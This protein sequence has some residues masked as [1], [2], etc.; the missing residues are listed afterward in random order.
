MTLAQ[1]PPAG[2][3]PAVQQTLFHGFGAHT[4][5]QQE[6][7]LRWMHSQNM[8]HMHHMQSAW[9]PEPTPPMLPQN[10]TPSH[11]TGQQIVPHFQ[12]NMRA[13]PYQGYG[14]GGGLQG[15]GFQGG[16]FQGGC[17]QGTGFQGGGCQGGGCF[18]PGFPEGGGPMPGMPPGYGMSG[19]FPSGPSNY[20]GQ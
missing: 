20:Q 9:F 6:Q 14:Q 19:S 18:P 1:A 5:D 13:S 2:Y 15:G 8:A 12:Q 10:S 4:Q 16:C 3:P 7:V 17:L 11:V